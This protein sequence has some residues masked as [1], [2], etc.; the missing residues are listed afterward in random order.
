MTRQRKEACE[1]MGRPKKEGL[2]MPGRPSGP[3]VKE[4]QLF[5]MLKMMTWKAKVVITK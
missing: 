1:D 5:M 2:G 4:T 3:P